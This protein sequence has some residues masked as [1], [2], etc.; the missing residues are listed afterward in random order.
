VLAEA[1]QRLLQRALGRVPKQGLAWARVQVRVRVQEQERAREKAL[2]RPLAQA[3]A[4]R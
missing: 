3:Q 1:S 2:V 4:P